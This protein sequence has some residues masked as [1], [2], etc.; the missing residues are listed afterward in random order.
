MPGALRLW[1]LEHFHKLRH[2]GRQLGST[3]GKAYQNR[4]IHTHAGC[5][6]GAH[7]LLG[8]FFRPKCRFCP[9]MPGPMGHGQL[10]SGAGLGCFRCPALAAAQYKS[11]HTNKAGPARAS[12]GQPF[13]APAFCFAVYSAARCVQFYAVAALVTK[14]SYTA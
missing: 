13:D 12:S 11:R 2:A 7:I 9:A 8:A 3:R 1:G 6:P 14:P 4:H 10:F 5:Q